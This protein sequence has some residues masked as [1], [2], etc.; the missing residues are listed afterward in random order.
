MRPAIPWLYWREA[1]VPASIWPTVAG[2]GLLA[3]AGTI[4]SEIQA[5][6]GANWEDS[7]SR[8]RFRVCSTCKPRAYPSICWE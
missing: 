5:P 6:L 2:G 1:G 4:A 7:R 3:V 8:P